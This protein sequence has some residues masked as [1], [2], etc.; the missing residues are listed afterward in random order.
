M[1]INNN[2]YPRIV[3]DSLALVNS[4]FSLTKSQFCWVE[5]FYIEGEGYITKPIYNKNG[6]IK[7]PFD[8]ETSNLKK[9]I[10][11]Y[12]AQNLTLV[13][14]IDEVGFYYLTK[15]C[16]GIEKMISIDDMVK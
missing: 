4:D 11:K 2:L 12:K 14:D 15:H 16:R 6:K 8:I 3:N 13:D 10:Y 1:K 5:K 7:S 9:G